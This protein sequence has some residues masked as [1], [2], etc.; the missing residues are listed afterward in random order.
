VTSSLIEDSRRRADQGVAMSGEVNAS[1]SAIQTTF[2]KMNALVRNV[3]EASREQQSMVGNITTAIGEMDTIIQT[4]AAGAEE[5]AAAS[6]ELSAQ[7]ESLSGVVTD[8]TRIMRG[9]PAQETA[10]LA[11][12]IEPP[13]SIPANGHGAGKGNG[14]SNGHA[15][16]PAPA[17]SGGNG[18]LRKRIEQETMPT[19]PKL[20]P[21]IS[22]AAQMQFRDLPGDKA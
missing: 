16:K 11:Q 17:R 12:R 19:G 5:T 20:P 15:A 22:R 8:L 13:A 21:E 1:L 7:A 6:E 18:S 9:G 10:H 4:N 3:A 2:D 14:S